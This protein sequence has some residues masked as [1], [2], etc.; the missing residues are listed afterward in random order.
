MEHKLLFFLSYSD[1]KD[2]VSGAY[3]N[4]LKVEKYIPIAKDEKLKNEMINET[5]INLKSKYKELEYLS[6]SK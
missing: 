6:L 1:N 5:I 2:L 3:Y 4:N